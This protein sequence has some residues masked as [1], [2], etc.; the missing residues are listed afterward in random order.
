MRWKVRICAYFLQLESDTIDNYA[1]ATNMPQLLK[2]FSRE[3]ATT[4]LEESS[5]GSNGHCHPHRFY[6]TC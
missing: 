5:P 1:V 2:E 3:M 6:T 4:V